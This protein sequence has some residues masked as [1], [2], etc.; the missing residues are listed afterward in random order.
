MRD[1]GVVTKC[2]PRSRAIGSSPD[3]DGVERVGHREGSA[4]ED[5]RARLEPG[6]LEQVADQRGHRL[7]DRTP[8]L[9]ELALDRLVGDVPVEDQVEVARQAGQRGPQLVGD[10]RHVAR[11]FRLGRAQGG[12]LALGAHRFGHQGQRDGGV[13]GELR[14]Q[15]L[16]DRGRVLGAGEGEPQ[17]DLAG[18]GHRQPPVVRLGGGLAPAGRGEPRR[19]GRHHHL[20]RA[21]RRP[22]GAAARR[23]RV[24]PC[25]EIGRRRGVARTRRRHGHAPLVALGDHRSTLRPDRVG[26]DVEQAGQAFLGRSIGGKDVER[27]RQQSRL[28]VGQAV[29]RATGSAAALD[30]GRRGGDARRARRGRSGSVRFGHVQI[31]GRGGLGSNGIPRADLRWRRRYRAAHVERA[32]LRTGRPRVR[33]TTSI[34]S[35][36]YWSASPRSAAVRTHP[37]T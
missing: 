23:C 33:R 9:E 25:R 29:G 34:T 16:P 3:A 27:Q 37:W 28:L 31:D 30:E 22:P 14:R 32:V 10:R 20:G 24:E 21:G 8:A 19:P 26:Q 36:T 18:T 7:D 2:T 4:L 11:A 12:E 5:E 15:P 1:G 6:Q 35:S 13:P 17:R